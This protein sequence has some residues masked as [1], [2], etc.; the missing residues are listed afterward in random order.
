MQAG[1]P[2]L[3]PSDDEMYAK[4]AGLVQPFFAE[5]AEVHPERALPLTFTVL[6]ATL[7]FTPLRCPNTS[8]P[9]AAAAQVEALAARLLE[10]DAPHASVT[11]ALEATWATTP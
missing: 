5:S 6:C 11:A 3:F 4:F 8:P 1:E 10:I 7:T 9:T 2:E